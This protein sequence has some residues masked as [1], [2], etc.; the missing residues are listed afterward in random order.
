VGVLLAQG[1]HILAAYIPGL[2]STL[3][4]EPVRLNEW[5][6]L[7]ALAVSIVLV[8]EGFKYYRSRLK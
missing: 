1:V 2:N 6:I 4:L 5:L 7:L 3:Q 8:M